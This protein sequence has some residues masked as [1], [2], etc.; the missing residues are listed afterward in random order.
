MWGNI[1]P[2]CVPF[3][4]EM[5][6]KVYKMGVAYKCKISRLKI[7]RGY[8]IDLHIF[9]KHIILEIL[10]LSQILVVVLVADK[11]NIIEME[12][13]KIRM[14]KIYRIFSCHNMITKVNYIFIL[15]VSYFC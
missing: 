10:L 7:N 5:I 12:L 2:T 6:I 14:E 1:F 3:L 15:V 8:H 4:N 13:A 9:G 11:S